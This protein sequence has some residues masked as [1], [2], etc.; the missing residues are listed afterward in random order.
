MGNPRA[1]AE[2][3]SADR[4]V[5]LL[6]GEKSMKYALQGGSSV[7][8]AV[9]RA[10]ILSASAAAVVC[11]TPAQAQTAAATDTGGVELQEVI[12]TGSLIKRS[13]AETP[14]PVQ[15]VTAEELKNSG[16]TDI[17]DV[18][19]NI[20][21]NGQGTL[22][23][24][25]SGAFAAGASGVALRGLTVGATL[26]LIDGE[27]MV[28]YPLTDDGE[29]NFVDVT[30]I[31]FAAVEQVQVLKDGASAEYGSD[32]LAGVVNIILRKQFQGA[33][34]EV[35]GGTSQ[36]SDADLIHV[37][38]IWGVGDLVNDG[39]N[40]YITA[41]YRNQGQ[42]LASRRDGR[43]TNG[44]WTN[45]GGQNTTPGA[46]NV[47]NGG[48][49]S[50]TTGYDVNSAGVPTDFFGPGCNATKLAASQC[51][52][53]N[54]LQLQPLLGNES[55]LMKFTKSMGDNWQAVTTASIF[56]TRS[57]QIAGHNTTGFLTGGLAI[58]A[59][60]PNGLPTPHVYPLTTVPATYPGNTTG[61]AAPLIYA[62]PE[63]GAPTENTHADTYRFMEQ[64]T[65]KAGGW[66]LGISAG[67]MYAR[68]RADFYNYLDP[69]AFQT[70]LD[71]GYILGTGG[72][73][74][75]AFAPQAEAIDSSKLEIITGHAA[76]SLFALPG[77]DAILA[78]GAQW[79]ENQ[80]SATA[81]PSSIAGT[82]GMNNAWA[83]GSQA[84][85]AAF[86]EI[87]LPVIKGL[88]VS[89]AGRYDQY[90]TLAGGQF[91][92]KFGVKYKPIDLVTVRGTWGKGFRA[93]SIAETNSGLAFGA[94]TIPD[95]ILCPNGA[96]ATA[97]G[98][99]PTQCVLQL[100][101]VQASNK[102]LKPEKTTNLTFGTIIEPFAG[103]SLSVDY[104]DI[105]VNQDIISAFEAGGLGIPA[106]GLVR[107]PTATLPFC[108]AD[109]VCNTP[110]TTPVGV[111]L[112]ESF[113]YI[114]ASK[115][116]TDGLDFDFQYKQALGGFGNL[117]THLTWTHIMSY[118]LEALGVDYQL[119]GTHGPTGISGDTGNPKDRGD[120][121]LTWDFGP[122]SLTAN[123]NYI[124]SFSV[125]DPSSGITDC[126]TAIY[127]SFN[128]RF[129]AGS[130][131]PGSYCRVGSF[132]TVDLF[133]RY[134]ITDKLGVHASILNVANTQP[135]LDVQTYGGTGGNGYAAAYD[136]SLHQAGAVGRF[137]T[138]GASYQF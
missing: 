7:S 131:F 97:A 101:G 12:V 68:L 120:L 106:G 122:A 49:P 9:R 82:Q 127:A 5:L 1:P 85:A 56:E 29:R 28:G 23:Q 48:F 45:V 80:D 39:Y 110:T 58:V 34:F 100:V 59:F 65:G 64:I 44:D 128:S 72:S 66:D 83:Q 135:P 24:G 16:Y 112:Y 51:T 117:T 78:L 19:R 114:N 22:A 96:N 108:T 3:P 123:V 31:P 130:S 115:D 129:P 105:K 93:P 41:E 88:E 14:S 81:P 2:K 113:P 42:I 4:A 102:A 73:A 18:L 76:H 57:Q 6:L 25:F 132:T 69:G 30:Q 36:H 92:P 137:F 125:T 95:P 99:F 75:A 55:V 121:Q 74:A 43:Y 124:A 46:S 90:N 104:Y 15:I 89:A 53:N 26:T 107:G 21:A 10:L 47:F 94:G 116:E 54:G 32:A 103:L 98:N 79:F 118:K 138:V 13:D 63:L 77:G 71:N 86:G 17:S 61:A 8:A 136:P 33:Q 70:S 35:E 126:A 84:D 111:V 91:T 11:Y 37:D 133:A 134:N 67:L 60:P 38:G 27:R 119:A 62:F 20:S 50:T 40:F 87:N 109:G 52:Y